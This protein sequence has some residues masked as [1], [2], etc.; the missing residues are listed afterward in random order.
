MVMAEETLNAELAAALPDLPRWVGARGLLLSGRCEVLLGPEGKKSGGYLVLES[1]GTLACVVHRPV[2]SLVAQLWKLDR[3]PEQIIVPLENAEPLRGLLPGWRELPAVIHVH[4][5][6][7]TLPRPA[8]T[9]GFLTGEEAG[10]IGELAGPLASELAG[11][12]ASELAGPLA[13]E[14]ARALERG[15]V[16]A[17]YEGGRPVS[18]AYAVHE[19]ERWF[20]LSIDTLPEYRRRGLGTSAAAFLIHHLLARG[21]QP[22]WGALDADSR[23]VAMAAKHGF[24]AV[25]RLLV[26]VAP[27]A[28]REAPEV[29]QVRTGTARQGG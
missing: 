19:T 28:E 8:N 2:A 10:R 4:P 25:D 24:R 26:F 29:T 13:S 15:P 18:F 16:A 17:A 20:D 9:T 12:L 11:P 7:A 1:D 22:V 6:P 27:G 5:A 3:T 21:K 23:S 14:L